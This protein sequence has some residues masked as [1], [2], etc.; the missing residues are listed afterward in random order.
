MERAR[1]HNYVNLAYLGSFIGFR[2]SRIFESNTFDKAT[3]SNEIDS[4]K[5]ILTSC[6]HFR[7]QLDAKDLK[8]TAPDLFHG[9]HDRNHLNPSLLWYVLSMLH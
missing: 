5:L 9:F 3:A 2:D 4:Q 8:A 1:F 6:P 7:D